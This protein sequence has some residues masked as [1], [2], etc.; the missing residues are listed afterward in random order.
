MTDWL[1]KLPYFRLT[2]VRLFG[3]VFSQAIESVTPDAICAQ[4]FSVAVR[5]AC[6]SLEAP[7]VRHAVRPLNA[8]HTSQRNLL[9]PM[10]VKISTARTTAPNAIARMTVG[11]FT[12]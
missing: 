2:Q 11:F 10:V 5:T 12:S 6:A 4:A 7:A 1:R 8:M 3:G 9:V